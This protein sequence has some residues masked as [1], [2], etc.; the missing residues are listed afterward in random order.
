MLQGHG[1]ILF[2]GVCNLCNK[3]VQ[4]IL[5]HD[6]KEY[7]L[8]ASLQ[9]EIGQSLL[10]QHGLPSDLNSVV[11]IEGDQTYTE[12]DVPLQICK[13][14]PKLWKL[15]FIG[16]LIPP[17][18]RNSL[19]RLIAKKRYSWWGQSESCMIPAPQLK[20]RFLSE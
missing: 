17:P 20:K 18:V 11:L 19:Y 15:L 14:L 7:F 4:F 16:K 6:H 8:F 13:R 12:S 1:I 10:K 2:D 5:K 9:S 3:T